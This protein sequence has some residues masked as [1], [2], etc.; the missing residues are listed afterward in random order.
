MFWMNPPLAFTPKTTSASSTPFA[1]SSNGA[2]PFSWLNTTKPP[3]VKPTRSLNSA[4]ALANTVVN[5]FF[6]ARPKS[7]SSHLPSQ[8]NIYE[9]TLKTARPKIEEKSKVS[10]SYIT[11]PPTTSKE[12]NA[13]FL[14]ALSPASQA[15]QARVKVR[16]WWILSINTL[17][18]NK[19]LRSNRRVALEASK[20]WRPLNALS[21]LTKVP[22][23]AHHVRTP[24]PIP[25]CLTKSVLFSPKHQ[26]RKNAALRPV[27][28]AS[29]LKEAVARPVK[30]T[31][32]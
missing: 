3:S 9:A 14:W 12:L 19:G 26:T 7:S 18:C 27:D 10:L 13:I 17:P 15:F 4:P 32:K 30:A 28:L 24:P 2:I 20:G 25:K 5:L 8:V 1:T 6:K 23:D 29:T 22:S 11:S 31:V 21:P 16:W